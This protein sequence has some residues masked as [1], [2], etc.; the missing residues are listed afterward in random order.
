MVALCGLASCQ[1]RGSEI[2]QGSLA[3][4]RAFA[5]KNCST[6]HAI[7]ATGESPY[8][9]AVPFR[10][11]S[12]YYPIENLAEALA[13][14]INVGHSGDVEMPEFTLSPVEIDEFLGYLT[15]LQQ[16]NQQ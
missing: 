11:L 2:T 15:S 10:E 12:Q 3:R 9:P 14:G 13:E 16:S 4:G 1:D 7:D 8:A 5:Q 6:C